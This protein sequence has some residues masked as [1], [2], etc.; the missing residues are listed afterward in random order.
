MPDRQLDKEINMPPLKYMLL[1]CMVING[2]H[3]ES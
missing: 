2:N 1:E 3:F